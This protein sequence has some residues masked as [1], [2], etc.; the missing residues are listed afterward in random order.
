MP[1][2]GGWVCAAVISQLTLGP[3]ETQRVSFQW[4][5]GANPPSELPEAGSLPPGIY[6]FYATLN[7]REEA[8]STP[9]FLVRLE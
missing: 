2:G 5:G 8:L 9:H 3:G 4:A 7:A 1:S 6:S